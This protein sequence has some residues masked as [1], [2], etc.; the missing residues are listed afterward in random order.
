MRRSASPGWNPI[1]R[2]RIRFSRQDELKYIPHL[3]IMRFW[4]RALRRAALPLAYTQGFSPHPRLSLAAPLAV[5]VTSDDEMLDLY[6]TRPVAPNLLQSALAAQIPRGILV[7]QV[8]AIHPSAPALPSQV[9]WAEYKVELDTGRADADIETAIR[10][11]LSRDTL[12]WKHSRDTGEHYYDL[13]AL[14][15]TLEVMERQTGQV[16]LHMRLRCDGSGSGRPEQ[17]TAALGFPDPPTSIHRSR[18]VLE[19]EPP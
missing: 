19:G 1:V 13:R 17:V 8:Q 3:S 15:S 9:R 16:V 12:P 14:I 7:L 10:A 6:L 5:G 4:E 11:L 18:L 2:W